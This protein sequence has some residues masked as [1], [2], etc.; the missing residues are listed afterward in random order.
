MRLIPYPVGLGALLALVV[1]LSLLVGRLDPDIVPNR[2]THAKVSASSPLEKS[3]ESAIIDGDIWHTAIKTRNENEPF[4]QLDFGSV[5]LITRVVVYNRTDCCQQEE[6][7][8]AIELSVDGRSF[9]TAAK[10]DKSF[11]KWAASVGPSNV[12]YLRVQLKRTGV[13]ALNEIEVL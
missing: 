8:L 4:I 2:A 12:R 10:T 1:A 7:P 11:E 9:T 13:L 3:A 5:I 6:V